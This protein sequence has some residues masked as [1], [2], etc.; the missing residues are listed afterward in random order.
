MSFNTPNSSFIF[1]LLRRSIT[2][3]AVFLA[4]FFPAALVELG[5]FLPGVDVLFL[6]AFLETGRGVGGLP[7]S[8]AGFALGFICIILRDRVGGGGS[9][10]SAFVMVDRD[11]RLLEGLLFVLASAMAG[12]GR[13][14]AI[15]RDESWDPVSAVMSVDD[16]GVG[17]RVTRGITSIGRECSN[18]NILSYPEMM[19]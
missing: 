15:S 1:D 9:E 4:I 7:D 17:G 16:T 5:G 6:P 14:K 12:G 18:S 8:W 3:W 19:N 13:R 2:E 10:K 11:N